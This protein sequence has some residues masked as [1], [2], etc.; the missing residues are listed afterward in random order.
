MRPGH[1]TLPS[2]TTGRVLAERS[3]DGSDAPSGSRLAWGGVLSAWSGPPP[4]L[5]VEFC[6][7]GSCCF[8]ESWRSY[9]YGGYRGLRGF[10]SPAPSGVR[11]RSSAKERGGWT[12]REVGVFRALSS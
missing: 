8:K 4:P 1:A 2:D 7:M 11:V 10:S 5:V 12:V 3:M 6:L 9:S